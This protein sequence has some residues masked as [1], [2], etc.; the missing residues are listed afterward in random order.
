MIAPNHSGFSGLD[1]MVL[2]HE[3]PKQTLVSTKILTHKLWFSVHAL[4]KQAEKLGFIE[5]SKENGI[6]ELERGHMVVLF[7]EGEAGNFKPT[8]QAYEIQ[9]FKRGIVRMALQTGA[10]IIPTVVI[11]AEETHINLTK[12]SFGK[13]LQLP[14]PLNVIPLPALWRIRF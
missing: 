14:L 1:A 13:H 6:K 4:G 9:T 8:K 5:A 10:P 11:G 3:L 12:L 2:A 7:P